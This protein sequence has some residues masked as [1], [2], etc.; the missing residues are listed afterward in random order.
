MSHLIVG[1]MTTCLFPTPQDVDGWVHSYLMR[2]GLVLHGT[3]VVIGGGMKV[4]LLV[5]VQNECL[6]K[7]RSVWVDI[8]LMKMQTSQ[9]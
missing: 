6:V 7:E 2:K 3:I 5:M 9:M 1:Y 4:E 8:V